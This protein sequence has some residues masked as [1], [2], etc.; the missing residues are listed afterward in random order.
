MECQQVVVNAAVKRDGYPFR[1]H[2]Q[3]NRIL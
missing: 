2:R 3:R 1:L